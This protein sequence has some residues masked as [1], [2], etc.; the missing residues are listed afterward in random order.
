MHGVTPACATVPFI[1][2]HYY[3][4]L[5][6]AGFHNLA[7]AAHRLGYRV[8]FITAGYSL[9]SC[10][11]RDYRTKL[12]GIRANCNRPVEIRPG[13]VSYVHRTL[14]HPHTL[15]LPILDRLTGPFMEHYGEGD[16]Q[17]LL[18]LVQETDIFVFESMSG[19]F[20]FNRFRREKPSARTIYRVSDDVRILRSTHPRLV[21]LEREIAPLLEKWLKYHAPRPRP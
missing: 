1:T 15:M 19:L 13:F 10:L 20:L 4:S 5:R 9:F 21:E 2:G 16:L 7:D 3:T 14:W 12:P 6:R 17:R 11:R 8:N 18:P